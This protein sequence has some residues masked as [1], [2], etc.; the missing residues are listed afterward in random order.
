MGAGADGYSGPAGHDRQRVHVVLWDSGVGRSVR[1]GGSVALS[2][3]RGLAGPWFR[4]NGPSLKK[5]RIHLHI[6]LH[7]L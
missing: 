5:I 1:V 6:G 2:G 3:L 7:M 4:Q